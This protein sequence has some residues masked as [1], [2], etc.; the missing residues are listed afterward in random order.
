M[1]RSLILALLFRFLLMDSHG[2]L[3]FASDERLLD[4]IVRRK[5]LET[6]FPNIGPYPGNINN[7]RVEVIK[8]T[9]TGSIDDYPYTVS[10]LNRDSNDKE[11][12]VCGGTLIA[13][14]IGKRVFF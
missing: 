5:L 7:H 3:V 9:P 10:L 8:G 11:W 6:N 12:H 14:N 13:R 2:K 1:L 4:Q